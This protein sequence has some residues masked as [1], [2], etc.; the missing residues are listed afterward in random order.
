MLKRADVLI[1]I[2]CRRTGPVTERSSAVEGVRA[3]WANLGSNLG[4]GGWKNKQAICEC[5]PTQ[6]PDRIKKWRTE[7]CSI[8]KPHWGHFLYL[9]LSLSLSGITNKN[10]CCKS[11]PFLGVLTLDTCKW[12]SRM[13]SVR[14]WLCE[15]PGFGV[16]LWFRPE[17]LR[18]L[19]L[20]PGQAPKLQA[21]HFSPAQLM[22][23]PASQA[24]ENR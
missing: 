11:N 22:R 12:C 23:A 21:L 13:F 17:V 20:W 14:R 9:C 5:M 3:H 7:N 15:G 16:E 24:R 2:K 6:D 4:P 1:K 18:L 19:A 8:T 10:K